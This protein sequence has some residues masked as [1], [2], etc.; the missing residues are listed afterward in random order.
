MKRV[1]TFVSVLMFGTLLSL[2]GCTP[3][4]PAER[5]LDVVYQQLDGA[6]QHF[7]YMAPLGDGPFPLIV[8]IHGGGWQRGS[9]KEY[10]AFQEAMAKG[11]IATLS[12]QYRFAPKA[13]FPAQLDDVFA[14]LNFVLADK[15]KYHVDPQRIGWLGGSAGGHLALLAG[16]TPAEHYKSLLIANVAGPTNMK[17]FQSKASGDKALTGAVGRNSLELIE[18]LLG[19]KNKDDAVY[20]SASPVDIVTAEAPRVFTAHGEK[21]DI[22]PITQAEELHKRL[23]E[24]GVSEKLFRSA[25]GG[26]DFGSWPTKDRNEGMLEMVQEINKALLGK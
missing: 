16:F 22:V 24:L 6:Q 21:D 3:Q 23:K 25:E 17:T 2:V 14:A 18:D 11:G 1:A 4:S 20:R 7:D 15:E 26:H 8:C 9:Y 13:K 12:V 10:T 5:H 19:S